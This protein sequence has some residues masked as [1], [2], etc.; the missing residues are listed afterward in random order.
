MKIGQPGPVVVITTVRNSVIG[1]S[2]PFGGFQGQYYDIYVYCVVVCYMPRDAHTGIS[3][4]HKMGKDECTEINF[5][6]Y[7]G[8]DL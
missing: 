8:V 6:L 2:K 1:M 5:L 3:S 4:L 7:G